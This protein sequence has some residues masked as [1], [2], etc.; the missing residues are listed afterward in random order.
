MQQEN[1]SPNRHH[2]RPGTIQNARLLKTR[3]DHLVDVATQLFI[4]SGFHKTT[5]RAIA[6][7]TGWSMG[8]LYLYIRR[9]EDILHLIS[10]RFMEEFEAQLLSPDKTLPPGLA[11]EEA[12]RR[13]FGLC[14]RFRE[15]ISLLYRESASMLR[16]HLEAIKAHELSMVRVFEGIIARGDFGRDLDETSVA[17]IGHNIVMLGHMWALKGWAL[18]ESFTIESYTAHQTRSIFLALTEPR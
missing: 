6:E 8:T 1:D 10:E 4:E 17:L 2:D 13:Y 15:N 18:H 12:I 3:H 7:A 16:D 5:I 11:L 14:D 9:K